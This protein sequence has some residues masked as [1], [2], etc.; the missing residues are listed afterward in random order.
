MYPLSRGVDKVFPAFGLMEGFK[1]DDGYFDHTGLIY[2]GEGSDDLGLGIKKLGYYTYRKMTEK[3]EGADWSTLAMLHYGTEDDHLYLFR[4]EKN[5]Q[6]IHVARWDYFDEPGNTS[7]DTKPITLTGLTGTAVTVTSVVPAA[8]TGQEVTDYATAFTVTTYSVSNGS[9]TIPLGEDPVVVEAAAAALDWDAPFG[10]LDAPPNPGE[11]AEL[12]N[13]WPVVGAHSA[14]W[15][16]IETT[17]GVYDWDAVDLERLQQMDALGIRVIPELRSINAL[18]ETYQDVDEYPDGNVAAW[19]NFVTAPVEKLDGDGKDELQGA[20]TIKTYSVLHKLAPS[21][22]SYWT[23]HPDE[24]AQMFDATYR[25]MKAACPD[26]VLF[27]PGGNLEH[28]QFQDEG[29]FKHGWIVKVLGCLEGFTTQ[30]DDM[31]FD[32]HHSARPRAHNDPYSDGF[33]YRR[34]QVLIEAIRHAYERF[35]YTD[36]VIICRESGMTGIADGEPHDPNEP[37]QAAYVVNMYT[38]I[39]SLEQK[40]CTWRTR[41]EY[42]HYWPGTPFNHMGLIHDS[43]NPGGLSH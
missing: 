20:P 28:F 26:C 16:D 40:V 24:Y 14:H 34:R 30:F 8:D 32:Y 23:D 2:D 7:G 4:V 17:P 13:G 33:D 38:L 43:H 42:A 6:P 39:A 35:G 25:A 5:G 19:Q 11:Y 27:L 41:V 21:S 22:V 36:L 15:E 1:R 37:L 12:S 18:Y 10:F 9:V 31:G 29:A 3:L